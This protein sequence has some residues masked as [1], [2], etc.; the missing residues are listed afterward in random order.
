MRWT[1]KHW[2]SKGWYPKPAVANGKKYNSVRCYSTGLCSLI[3][4]NWLL[5][6]LRFWRAF[7]LSFFFF[8]FVVLKWRYSWFVVFC[9]IFPDCL[10]VMNG[11]ERNGVLCLLQMSA[12][13]DSVADVATLSTQWKLTPSASTENLAAAAECFAYL[14]LVDVCWPGLHLGVREGHCNSPGSNAFH[15]SRFPSTSFVLASFS[16]KYSSS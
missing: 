15:P 4:W 8:S 2:C 13:F 11:W 12:A 16:Y 1:T 6:H 5:I 9:F 3:K 10:V 7:F 14:F